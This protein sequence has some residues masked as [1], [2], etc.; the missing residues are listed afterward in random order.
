M[1]INLVDNLNLKSS[2]NAHLGPMIERGKIGIKLKNPLLEDIKKIILL[3]NVQKLVN[4]I[5]KKNTK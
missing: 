3:W 2:L 1:N 4:I 5:F